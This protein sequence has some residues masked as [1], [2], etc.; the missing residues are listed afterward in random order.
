LRL[1]SPI[2]SSASLFSDFGI[3]GGFRGGWLLEAEVELVAELFIFSSCF[4]SLYSLGSLGSL[5]SLGSLGSLEDPSS[6][7]FILSPLYG[8]RF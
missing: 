8:L 4:F 5:C 3:V 6:S 1:Y 7:F 2:E